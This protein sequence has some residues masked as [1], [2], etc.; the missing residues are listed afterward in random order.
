M[1]NIQGR[2]LCQ[3]PQ[4]GTLQSR[5]LR[6]FTK[7]TRKGFCEGLGLHAAP[8]LSSKGHHEALGLRYL[9]NKYAT[10][11]FYASYFICL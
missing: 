8:G 4:Q 7:H 1:Q 2:G 6:G 3:T 11:G 9:G 10:R 5:L